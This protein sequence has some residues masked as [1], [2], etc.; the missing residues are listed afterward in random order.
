MV[1]SAAADNLDRGKF[2][3]VAVKSFNIEEVLCAFDPSSFQASCFFLP[4]LNL[5]LDGTVTIKVV[6]SL[7]PIPVNLGWIIKNQNLLICTIKC[8]VFFLL[9]YWKEHIM[10]YYITIGFIQL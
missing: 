5:E 7:I 3:P 10:N 1:A 9:S 2:E 6:H 4:A 8:Y